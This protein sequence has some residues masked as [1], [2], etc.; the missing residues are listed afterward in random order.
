MDRHGPIN[1][2][3][4]ADDRISDMEPIGTTTK[5]KTILIVDDDARITRLLRTIF[6]EDESIKVLVADDGSSALSSARNESP[7]LIFLDVRLPGVDGIEVCKR[8]KNN[9]LTRDIKVVIM[10]GRVDAGQVA[11]NVGADG[12]LDKPFELP[13]L[14]KKLEA[15]L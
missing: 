12:H 14:Q 1:T 11:K 6:E 9:R 13:D 3:E 4:V 10:S 2:T 15:L 5:Q 8:L 7:D